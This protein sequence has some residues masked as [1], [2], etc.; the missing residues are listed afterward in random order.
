VFF[1]AENRRRE[2]M[3]RFGLVGCGT[4]AQWAVIPAI[5]STPRCRLE[6]VADIVPD[7][8]AKVNVPN[9]RRYADYR[10]MLAREKLDAVYVA[11]PCE[12]HC[13][14]TLAALKAGCHVV[15][16]KPMAMKAKDCRRMI[17]AAESAGKMLV[18]DFECRYDP[19]NQQVRQWIVE[20]RIGAVR[21]IHI[22][23][24]WDGHKSSGD[25]SK[26]REG[27]LQR[28]GCLDCGIHRLDLVRFFCGGEW[29]DVH[30]LGSWM[31]EKT[32]F[33]PH[34]A[35]MARLTTGVIVT[36]NASFSYTAH[37]K[38]THS[39]HECTV[40]GEKGV[41]TLEKDNNGVKGFRLVSESLSSFFPLAEEGHAEAIPHVLNEL[42]AA[43]TEKKKPSP[44]L[45]MGIDGL[46]AQIAMDAANQEAVRIGDVGTM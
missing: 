31:G 28:N 30:A 2:G 45:A 9:V 26:R 6:A 13:D 46:M 25:L 16:E 21:A 27:F 33:P 23:H 1:R 10:E 7:N 39:Y 8:L 41:V 3:L 20:G 11:T 15:C 5:T 29:Q 12:V 24:M 22:D 37:I 42:D 32:R 14:P 17:A 40:V 19:A 44:S 35:I 36:V 4:H 18:I 34:I 38:E 43:V